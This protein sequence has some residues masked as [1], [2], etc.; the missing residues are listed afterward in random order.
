MKSTGVV[1]KIDELSRIVIPIELRRTMA[2]T[3]KIPGNTYW[4]EKNLLQKYSPGCI[5]CGDVSEVVIQRQL[6]SKTVLL[7]YAAKQ[8]LTGL[9]LTGDLFN[10][11]GRIVIEAIL[12]AKCYYKLCLH[13]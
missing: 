6:H 12:A 10:A 11:V 7:K 3:I 4:K 2:L 5:F 1:R 13:Q 8:F 9:S